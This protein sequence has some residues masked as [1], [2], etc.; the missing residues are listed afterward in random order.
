MALEAAFENLVNRLKELGDAIAMLQWGAVEDR[1]RQ[2]DTALFDIL[3]GISDDLLALARATRK[4]AAQTRKALGPPP[5]FD[6]LRLHVST[7]Q[8]RFNEL[9]QRF[10]A[11][12]LAYDRIAELKQLER[13]PRRSWRAWSA[14]VQQSI[15]RCREP[16]HVANQAFLLCWQEIAE[17]AGAT[18]FSFR[19]V[20]VGSRLDTPS[21]SVSPWKEP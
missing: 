13:E 17:R 19:A 5:D 2:G 21:V 8:E 10:V 18:N 1:P 4:S 3:G 16:L 6:G 9:H 7:C 11:E 14:E 12:L 15:E 20:G